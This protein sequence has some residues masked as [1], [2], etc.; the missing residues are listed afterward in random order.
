MDVIVTVKAGIHRSVFIN[1][2][3][4]SDIKGF[5]FKSDVIGE[6]WYV[7]KVYTVTHWMPLPEP[8]EDD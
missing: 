8:A 3:Y 4:N 6:D 5:E 2:R 1:A 7:S